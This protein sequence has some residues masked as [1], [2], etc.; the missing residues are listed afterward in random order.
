VAALAVAA[1]ASGATLR[2]VSLTAPEKAFLTQYKKLVPNLN[3]ASGA[4]ISAVTKS[5]TYTDAQIGTVF[6]ASAKQ[7]ASATAPLAKLKAP[8]PVAATFAKVTREIPAVE[9]DLI[10]VANAGGPAMQRPERR[11]AA[12]SRPISTPSPRPSSSSGRCSGCTEN[13]AAAAAAFGGAEIDRPCQPSLRSRGALPSPGRVRDGGWAFDCVALGVID[14]VSPEDRGWPGFRRP[15]DCLAS[16][17]LGEHD[18]GFDHVSV[19]RVGVEVADELES[20][21]RL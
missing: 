2:A 1:G 5:S 17:S 9:A 8:S 19:L 12:S 13:Q 16:E 6:T 20:N 10:A 7:W 15:R 3:K 4:V 18:D 21:V 14:A 11:R